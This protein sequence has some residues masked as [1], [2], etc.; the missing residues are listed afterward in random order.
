MDSRNNRASALGINADYMRVFPNP[1]ASIN[2]ADR[3]NTALCYAFEVTGGPTPGHSFQH[4]GHDVGMTG[5]KRSWS[6]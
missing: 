4:Q 6:N 1:D 5:Y 3:R 2:E